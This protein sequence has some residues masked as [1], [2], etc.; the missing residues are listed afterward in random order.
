MKKL[1][2][3]LCAVLFA[4]AAFADMEFL[5]ETS[6]KID[7]LKTSGVPNNFIKS[8]QSGVNDSQ[9]EALPLKKNIYHIFALLDNT[10]GSGSGSLGAGCYAFRVHKE[11][12]LTAAHCVSH[13]RTPSGRVAVWFRKVDDFA[14]KGFP[15]QEIILGPAS[16]KMSDVLE[17]M[18]FIPNNYVDSIEQKHWAN[19]YALIYIKDKGYTDARIKEMGKDSTLKDFAALVK[20]RYTFTN[21]KVEPF[22]LFLNLN[23]SDKQL[24]GRSFLVFPAKDVPAGTINL[25]D[26]DGLY[27]NVIF[28]RGAV[29]TGYSGSP[30]IFRNKIISV[31][32]GAVKGSVLAPSFTDEFFEFLNKSAGGAMDK[33]A[34][35]A[36][37]EDIITDELD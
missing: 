1:L 21:R 4:N 3:L 20:D 28:L 9:A 6:V 10:E 5:K 32:S 27:Q 2:M 36:F 16:D 35:D 33:K 18:V 13:L 24:K 30:I 23:D 12:L 8:V 31:W 17:G 22:K 25:L 15:E 26:F 14:Q 19:D 11:W 34:C 7:T 37:L 29:D